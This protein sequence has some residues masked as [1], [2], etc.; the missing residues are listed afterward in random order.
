M[1][2]I[3]PKLIGSGKNFSWCYSPI[4]GKSVLTTI[5]KHADKFIKRK[6]PRRICEIFN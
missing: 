4:E 3:S 6:H 2:M 5:I 1:N